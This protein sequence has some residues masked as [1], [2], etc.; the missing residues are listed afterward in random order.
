MSSLDYQAKKAYQVGM[1][2]LTGAF[3]LASL[4]LGGIW[5]YDWIKNRPLTPT[6][7][8]FVE[9]KLGNVDNKINSGGTVELGGQR[10]IKSPEEGAVERLLVQ[11]GDKISPG[12]ELIILRNPQRETILNKSQ[13]EI[14]KQELIIERNRE[15]IEEAQEK[16]RIAQANYEDDLEDYQ[17]EVV[18]KRAIKDLEIKKIKAQI[19]RDRQKVEEAKYSLEAAEAE[20]ENLEKLLERGFVAQQE[21]DRQ[22]QTVRERQTG[23][24]DAELDFKNSQIELETEQVKELEIQNSVSSSPVFEAEIELQQAQS[25]WKQSQSELERLKVEYQEAALTLENN[26]VTAPIDGVILN[27]NVKPGDGVNRSDELMSLGDPDQELIQLQLSTLDAAKVQPNQL[28]RISIIGPNSETFTG[29]VQSIGL[30]ARS[31]GNNND[32]E[33]GQATVPATIQLDQPTRTLIP[34]SAVSVEIILEERNNVV[35][36][37]TELIQREGQSNYV[38]ALD[39]ENTAQ[40]QPVTL[41]LEGLIQVEITS[42]LKAGDTIIS[43]LPETKLEPGI[44]I[45]EASSTPSESNTQSSPRRN[46]RRN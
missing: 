27:I 5:G 30:Q 20:L 31:S 37:N 10:T 43:P 25:E 42:G 12:Q 17:Q 15:K 9:V 16:L 29:R 19:N 2:W 21:I 28:A 41:G 11:S 7:A 4:S 38:W 13:L 24:R 26:I 23:L 33:S 32:S 35:V 18:S 8:E 46:R 34:G 14:Q 6:S 39:S 40:K 22:R 36:L 3:I 1:R 44:P 45:T